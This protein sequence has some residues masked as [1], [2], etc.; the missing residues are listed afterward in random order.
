LCFITIHVLSYCCIRLFIRH[1]GPPGGGRR[2]LKLSGELG[3]DPSCLILTFG[4]RRPPGSGR[5]NS[6]ALAVR[7]CYLTLEIC[8]FKLD[9]LWA[10]RGWPPAPEIFWGA[11]GGPLLF[12][13]SLWSAAA[14][15]IRSKKRCRLGGPNLLSNP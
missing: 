5:K 13:I 2:P 1:P 8:G 14:P 12:D 7:I 9:L 6:A 3:S 10:A 15:G 4:R 11:R